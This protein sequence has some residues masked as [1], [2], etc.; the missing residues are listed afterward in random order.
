MPERT[1]AHSEFCWHVLQSPIPIIL[2]DSV[3]WMPFQSCWSSVAPIRLSGEL[4][5]S[6]VLEAYE[7]CALDHASKSLPKVRLSRCT[8]SLVIRRPIPAITPPPPPTEGN[9]AAPYFNAV[10]CCQFAAAG[11]HL[12]RDEG[13]HSLDHRRGR[14]VKGLPAPRRRCPWQEYPSAC[15]GPRQKPV[16]ASCDRRWRCRRNGLSWH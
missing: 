8:F 6:A 9:A 13:V 16:R 15:R 2:G 14:V 5:S 12:L 4:E 1:E 7:Q 3:C 11:R 10:D